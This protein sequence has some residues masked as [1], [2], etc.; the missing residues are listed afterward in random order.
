MKIMNKIKNIESL[1]YHENLLKFYNKEKVHYINNH[2]FIE[3][4][5]SVPR[6][7]L[8]LDNND[9]K[10]DR[11]I[12]NSV[13]CKIY[14]MIVNV[15][16]IITRPI[17]YRNE[18]PMIEIVYEELGIKNVDIIEELYHDDNYKKLLTWALVI[19]DKDYINS[20]FIYN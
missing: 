5:I 2:K 11:L 7:N 3:K 9:S 15:Y 12:T 14:N 4:Y 16:L 6:L 1:S 20:R 17:L 8:F 18:E 13:K 10:E 19:T